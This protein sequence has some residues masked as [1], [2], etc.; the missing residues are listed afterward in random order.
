M[1]AQD[2]EEFIRNVSGQ[3]CKEYVL[4]KMKAQGNRI[5][6]QRRILLDVI[7]DSE[8]SCC[9]EIYYNA[10]KKDPSIGIATVYRMVNLLE[11]LG[12]IQKK[13]ICKLV[14]ETCHE[15]KIKCRVELEDGSDLELSEK[16]LAEVLENGLE[17]R[18]YIKG[19][20]IREISLIPQ[21]K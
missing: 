5:T 7:L 17:K 20:K 6:N 10:V 18:G 4:E 19:K 15:G 11:E 14:H 1:K 16:L 12:A 3:N 13:N 9:K 21:N 8:S 2:T